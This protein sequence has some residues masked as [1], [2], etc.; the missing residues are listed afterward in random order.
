MSLIYC[1]GNNLIATQKHGAGISRESEVLIAAIPGP[2]VQLLV[3]TSFYFCCFN[4]WQ[5]DGLLSD[6][7]CLAPCELL[8]HVVYYWGEIPKAWG[9]GKSS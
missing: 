2:M 7:V 3:R 5:E 6:L 4:G 1:L 9:S 8:V